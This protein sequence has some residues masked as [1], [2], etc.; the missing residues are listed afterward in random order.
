[1]RFSDLSQGPIAH[2]Q[3]MNAT[4]L[5]RYREA[6]SS[7]S[8]NQPETSVPPSSQIEAKAE[9]D[10]KPQK[11]KSTKRDQVAPETA[12]QWISHPKERLSDLG[13]LSPRIYQDIRAWIERPLFYP[14]VYHHIGMDPPRGVLICGPSGCGKTT[15][16]F[17]IANHYSLPLL[18]VSATEIISGMSGESESKLR[19]IFEEAK[20]CQPCILFIDDIDAIITKKEL[21]QRE[22][23]KRI[24]SQLCACMDDQRHETEKST[25]LVLAATSRPETLDPSLRRPGR[26]DH[27]ICM[28]IPDEAAREQILTMFIQKLK[29]DD[30]VHPK[31]LARNTPGYTG[32]D[33]KM[34]IR[35]AAM[36]AVQRILDAVDCAATDMHDAT[37]GQKAA[38]HDRTSHLD[39]ILPQV[40]VSMDDFSIALERI[41]PSAKRE[42]FAVIPDV[43][44][45]DIGALK[46]V[47]HELRLAVVEPLR[48]PELYFSVG[49]IY[50]AGVLLWGPP[51]CGKTLLAKAVA[52]QTHSNF[53]SIKGPELLNKYV[54]ESERAVRQVFERARLSA[55]CIIFFDELD[56]LCPKR[57]EDGSYSSRI[58]NQLL[59]EMDG[60]E[61]RQQ[62]YVLG[63]TN[64]PDII[65]PAM[66]RPGRLDKLIYVRLPDAEERWD[67]LV[68]QTNK[69]PLAP[70]VD[71]HTIARDPR[72]E[73]FSG[74]DLAA[75]IREASLC[76]IQEHIT[77]SETFQPSIKVSKRDFEMALGKVKPSVSEASR[78]IYETLHQSMSSNSHM[79]S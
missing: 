43:T 20:R 30:T 72:T 62:V 35:E 47:R 3:T 68:H 7:P 79:V 48:Q 46:E 6:S 13:G 14:Q 50:P 1:M 78:G 28:G 44:W 69:T 77:G 21:A 59:T 29:V 39:A 65:D 54:G 10:A 32:A 26:F 49:L 63:A 52:N 19:D 22:M 57:E 27:E 2:Q 56:A 12:Y 17:A 25:L 40:M 45:S 76:A 53:I 51:G 15:L 33:L 58:V 41:Q 67:I 55:P 5:K 60:L 18:K 11:K 71:L 75:L 38:T 36:L 61:S 23:E 37:L 70:D 34:L 42:G 31:H 73:G 16:A 64:R 66:L 74:A 8:V 24:V 9:P 4:I